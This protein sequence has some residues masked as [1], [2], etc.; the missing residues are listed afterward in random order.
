MKKSHVLILLTFIALFSTYPEII[1]GKNSY[2]VCTN[3]N[4]LRDGDIIKRYPVAYTDTVSGG[5]G[6]LWDIS[7]LQAGKPY[8]VEIMLVNDSLK[9]YGIM[10]R[11]TI[12]Y[13]DMHGD[14]ISVAGH[15]NNQWRVDYDRCE[16]WLIDSM[17]YGFSAS[18][19]VHGKGIYCDR[20]RYAIA[21]T[22]SLSADAIG[23]LIL[24]DCDTLRNV[25]RVHSQRIFLHSY[26]PID[27]IA[28]DIN[29]EEIRRASTENHLLIYDTRRWYAPGYRYPV[30]ETQ[31]ITKHPDGEPLMRQACYTHPIEM[32]DL[33]NDPENQELRYTL[34][35]D[36]DKATENGGFYGD[37]SIGSDRTNGGYD[38]S[39]DFSQNK[40]NCSVT[41][42]YNVSQ[43]TD[44]EFIL[45]DAMGIV[46]SSDIRR[47]A[48]DEDY[49]VTISYGNIPGAGPYVLYINTNGNRYA[50]KFYK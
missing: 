10:E 26:Y 40:S 41:V 1:I 11:R 28:A 23:T 46:Y 50:E 13:Y 49:S 48:P 5:K 8:N 29:A 25:Q 21:G 30:L 45:A 42:G 33:P 32:T 43:H 9:R 34:C 24:P 36:T 27:S 12:V 35:H 18:G 2:G 44:V 3:R 20:L 7:Y 17:D 16:P 37:S 22:Y 38:F 4:G 39:Y 15:E 19:S 14:S 31:T 47:C 6:K